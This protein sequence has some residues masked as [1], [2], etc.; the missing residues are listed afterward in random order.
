[1]FEGNPTSVTIGTGTKLRKIQWSSNV[2]VAANFDVSG[3]QAV[4]LPDGTWYDYL[5]GGSLANGT[6][7]LAPGELKVFTGTPVQ[8]PTFTD[9]SKRDH[10][11]VEEVAAQEVSARKFMVDG[12]I[13]IQCGDRIY[14]ITGQVVR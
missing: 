7:T 10:Q 13:Y 5:E 11:D 9:I 12:Q 3:N 14:T 8:A 6:Y 2:F 4:T 1:V